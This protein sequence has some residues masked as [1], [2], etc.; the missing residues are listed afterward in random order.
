MYIP[1]SVLQPGTG[2]DLR[3][4]HSLHAVHSPAIHVVQ[5]V[6][7]IFSTVGQQGTVADTQPY[8]GLTDVGCGSVPLKGSD[9]NSQHPATGSRSLPF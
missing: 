8:R 3:E 9:R 7:L 5:K 2:K 4:K 6:S 1:A